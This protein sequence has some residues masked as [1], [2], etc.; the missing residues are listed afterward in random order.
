MGKIKRSICYTKISLAD[1]LDSGHVVVVAA[2]VSLIILMIY[3]CV[4]NYLRD[5]DTVISAFELLPAVLYDKRVSMIAICGF[6]LLICDVPHTMGNGMLYLV[7]GSKVEWITGQAFYVAAVAGLYLLFMWGITLLS[8]V[9]QF[10]ISSGWTDSFVGLC[11][12]PEVLDDKWGVVL[13]EIYQ[14]SQ[15]ALEVFAKS[16][17]LHFLLFIMMGYVC[18][19]FQAMSKN[20]TGYLILGM[21]ICMDIGIDLIEVLIPKSVIDVRYFSPVTMAQSCGNRI[22]MPFVYVIS[23]YLAVSIVFFGMTCVIVKKNSVS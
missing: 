11:R 8:L 4:G 12:N 23:V 13:R 14:A 9:P 16:M 7:R 5:T 18:M 21:M 2:V 1:T 10:I 17:L 19:F 3:S 22:S 15:T 20:V 6:I